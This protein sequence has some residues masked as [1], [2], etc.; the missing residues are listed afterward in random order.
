METVAQATRIILSSAVATAITTAVVQ[1]VAMVGGPPAS[2]LPLLHRVQQFQLKSHLLPDLPMLHSITQSMNW[3]NLEPAESGVSLRRRLAE[4]PSRRVQ[5]TLD[6][7]THRTLCCA[8][9]IVPLLL[10]HALLVVAYQRRT[11]R[12]VDHL[13]G[14]PAFPLLV[15][16]FLLQPFVDTAARFLA[17]GSSSFAWIGVGLLCVFP[18][19]L[20]VY[21]V[22]FV[23]RYLVP[24]SSAVYHTPAPET[25]WYHRFWPPEGQWVYVN[26]T[27]APFLRA[28]ESLF[29]DFMGSPHT[30][31]PHFSLEEGDA[32]RFLRYEALP[33]PH[34]PGWILYFPAFMLLKTVVTTLL[35]GVAAETPAL[36]V[37]ALLAL[38]HGLHLVLLLVHNP[39]SAPLGSLAETSNV[40]LELVTYLQSICVHLRP[41]WTSP[42]DLGMTALQL[43]NQAVTICIHCWTARSVLVGAW[44]WFQRRSALQKLRASVHTARR[45]DLL[46]VKKYA[47]RWLYRTHRRPLANW[48]VPDHIASRLM[49]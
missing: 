8:L 37:A 30:V 17:A 28:H 38:C 22:W 19:P 15:G 20:L 5:R 25:R 46:R 49:T 24:R 13:L 3:I 35:L 31:L 34:T 4:K 10:L 26:P 45:Q 23:R 14:L 36:W 11:R 1:S 29:A 33:A 39:S 43:L 40:L 48:P 44:H 2:F 12:R 41:L 27:S 9:V 7:L 16:L 18:L 6:L 42:L 21:T 32:P 47:N